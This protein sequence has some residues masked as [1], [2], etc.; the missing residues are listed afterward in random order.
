MSPEVLQYKYILNNKEVIVNNKALE[1]NGSVGGY[2]I[3]FLVMVLT[4]Y[5]P[6]F[7]WPIGMNFFAGWLADSTL[8]NGKSVTYKAQY[9]ETLKFYVVNMLLIIVT[10]GIYVFWFVPKLFRYIV[11]HTSYVE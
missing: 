6:I 4:A 5:I 8:V 3:A 10:L 1:F 11:D 7:G 2:F 9:G